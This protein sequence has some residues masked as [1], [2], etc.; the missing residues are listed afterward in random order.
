DKH[1]LGLFVWPTDSYMNNAV[2]SFPGLLDMSPNSSVIKPLATAGGD[3]DD[4]DGLSGA[5]EATS[6]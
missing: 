2:Q 3:D 4:D 5:H 1:A 6:R